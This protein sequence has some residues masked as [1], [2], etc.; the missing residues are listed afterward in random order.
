MIHVSASDLRKN[1]AHYM[2]RA[3]ADR[4]PILVTRQGSEPVVLLAHSE[5]E[6]MMETLYLRRSPANAA[7]LDASIAEL[8]AGNGVEHELSDL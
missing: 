1:L 5:F 7:R 3:E 8:E 2:D 4:D 6:S